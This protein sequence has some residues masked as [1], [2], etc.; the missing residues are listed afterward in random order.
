MR[1]M[2]DPFDGAAERFWAWK[3][4]MDLLLAEAQC[5]P[6]ESLYILSYN[7]T[8]RP[9]T[10][11]QDFLSNC[12]DPV[13]T[14]RL[15][16]QDLEKRF[17][18]SIRVSNRLR[19]KLQDLDRIQDPSDI[20]PMEELLSICRSIMC[21]MESCRDLQYYNFRNGLEEIWSKMP[22]SF[23]DRWKRESVKFERRTGVTPEIKYLFQCMS[24][25]IDENS[26]PTFRKDTAS[27][28]PKK[29]KVLSTNTETPTQQPKA[30][31]SQV[32]DFSTESAAR[33][34]SGPSQPNF[35]LYHQIE[36]HSVFNCK[37]F[38]RLS[39][40]DKEAF[41]L[42]KKRCFRCLGEHFAKNC[43][44]KLHCSICQG[45]HYSVMHNPGTSGVSRASHTHAVCTSVC[46]DKNSKRCCS[47]TLP[48]EVRVSGRVE[49]HKILCIIDE[50][51]S[52]SFCDPE[53][54]TLLGLHPASTTYSISTMTGYK[55]LLEG[56][57]VSGLEVRGAGESKWIPLPEILT[58]PFIPDTSS[59]VATKSVV[60]AHPHI[61][62][63]VKH[64][65]T[66]T[67]ALEVRMLLGV[68]C[69]EV[70]Y[71]QSFG[72]TFPYAHHTALGWCLVG[73]VCSEMQSAPRNLIKSLRTSAEVSCDHY[74]AERDF[75]SNYDVDCIPRTFNALSRS[76]NDE[77]PGMSGEDRD[78]QDIVESR[79][80]TNKRGNYELPLPL[81]AGVVLPDNR[82]MVYHRTRNTL[83][84]IASDP[85][86]SVKCTATMQ[87]Y[88]DF[89]HVEEVSHGAAL[90]GAVTNYIAVFPVTQPSK[91]DK[92]RLV[93]DSS[94]KCHGISLNDAL[95]RGPDVANRLIG[96]LLR[97]RHHRVGF[98]G[99]VECMFHAF[100]VSP[101]HRDALRFFWWK[102]NDPTQA[103]VTYRANVHVFGNKSSPAIATFGLRHT[104]T[105]GDA[106]EMVSAKSFILNNFYVDDGMGSADTAEE[107]IRILADTR[108]IL[109]NKNIR[110]HKIISTDDK[111]LAAFPPSELA[112]AL[113][114]VDIAKSPLHSALGLTWN[115]ETDCFKLRYHEPRREFTRR[116][117]LSVNGSIYDPLGMASP[118]SLKG[119]LLQRHFLS[120]KEDN[121]N[122]CFGWDDLL[123]ED[124]LP[125][126]N[127]WVSQLEHLDKLSL[128]RCF[129]Q[130][131]TSEVRGRELHVF[132]DASE[133]AI[134]HVIYL[135]IIGTDDSVRV[136][137]VFAN[138]KVSPRAAT[139]IP[140]LELCAAVE[141][142][143]SAN[144]LSSE[145]KADV[146]S[147]I[148]YSDSKIVLGYLNNEHRSF[149]NYVANR[150]DH[151][152]RLSSVSQWKYIPSHQNPADIGSRPKT[153]SELLATEW[154]SGPEFLKR[155]VLE[156]SCVVET[157]SLLPETVI[158]K[159]CLQTSVQ[160]NSVLL[161]IV[162]RISTWTAAVNV[163]ANLLK[164]IYLCRNRPFQRDDLKGKASSFL[165]RESQKECMGIEFET[166]LNRRQLPSSSKL[167]S[168]A[169]FIGEQSLMRVGGRLKNCDLPYG[170]KHPVLLPPNHAI[171]KLVTWHYHE[172]TH[173]QGRH[174]T[175]AAL[176]SGGFH[177]LNQGRVISKLISKCVICRK[178]RQS[179][180][181]QRMADFP[182]D[183]LAKTP[184]F[185]CS[186]VDV[187]GPYMVK[188]GLTTRRG[189]SLKKVWVLLLTCLYS[190]AVH[191][192]TLGSLDVTSLKLALR[193]FTAIRGSCQL[194]RS[195]CGTNFVGA[196]NLADSEVE[197]ER[198]LGESSGEEHT[199]KFN[200]P[201]AS[202]FAGV[203]E[204]KVGAIKSVLNNTIAIAGSRTLSR[205]EFSTFLL[206]AVSIVNGTP[207][208]VISSDPNDPFPV[209]PS[210]L[211]TLRDHHEVSD[212]P[213][214]GT[215]RD[216][217]SYGKLRWK[218]V[219]YLA[220]E[221][222]TR[223][224]N[225]Y[226]HALQIRRKWH[227]PARN[228]EVGDVVMLRDNTP[229]NCWPLG[230]VTETKK[231]RDGLVRSVTVKLKPTQSGSVRVMRR[232][233][234]DLIVILQTQE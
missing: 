125:A 228:V 5:D 39:H 97:F 76:P 153:T 117:I 82:S 181:P 226:I 220:E 18:S 49:S 45:N 99:D 232:A 119:R 112:P 2:G 146:S 72:K 182:D 221:F 34:K 174:L 203:W 35:C 7:T 23:I 229:R 27:R 109:G 193:R 157:P 194:F 124:L 93:F 36:G 115:I 135:R 149:T 91:P 30:Q 102:E 1:G 217:L 24:D 167:L 234:H 184:P 79:I 224:K 74:R 53:L 8:G 42:E 130:P 158:P 47:K 104:T 154:F 214:G 166:M 44:R 94:S 58:N 110:L 178:L 218:R 101:E 70:M 52:S 78:F 14:L 51:S 188:E 50:Q 103:L 128:P 9:K 186:G 56:S 143:Q 211:L 118:V 13:R 77:S 66:E 137:F 144:Y 210:N 3:T 192:E 219:R 133:D 17:G 107:A 71:T 152:L 60:L 29:H 202:H 92:V 22:N 88:L 11:L 123:P 80:T 145:L 177:V 55:T 189:S 213:P 195:D 12:N 176:R 96:V 86:M 19:E 6:L 164:F 89:G 215:D 33:N 64:F 40:R 65:P 205:E 122:R 179:P 46:G 20:L 165:I 225:D 132:A 90:T 16:W 38:G 207:L 141:A 227:K 87:K 187:F 106:N 170:E 172:T 162:S 68:D 61:Q 159:L 43:I 160:G 168:L 151:I 21:G 121:N 31:T 212:L 95:L 206:E 113:E 67:P 169:P 175:L 100:H 57:A 41:A 54:P 129:K 15:A 216:L 105:C 230:I 81:K 180:Q 191:V 185:S 148:F 231:C 208:G 75:R 32:H 136:S 198:L 233:V 83:H 37:V 126:W 48:I 190:R 196:Q 10:M 223:W 197:M 59:E 62:H 201:R 156:P 163:I 98:A 108:K 131:H 25:F 84:R 142:A 183:R 73:P 150:K 209:S 140:R 138:S 85:V 155:R 116:G 173:H 4:Q 127:K 200:P 147:T 134:A 114:S 111:V 139:T 171:T 222:W 69:G 199:W 120:Q 63:L 28:Y 26:D 204:R 161:H